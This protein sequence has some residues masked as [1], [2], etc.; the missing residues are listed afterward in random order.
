MLDKSTLWF[1]LH[2]RE[3]MSESLETAVI[4]DDQDSHT[5]DATTKRRMQNR[6]AQRT[7][8]KSHIVSIPTTPL[9]TLIW[10]TW[11]RCTGQR[12]A[13]QKRVARSSDPDVHH[14]DHCHNCLRGT[15]TEGPEVSSLTP[16]DA[17]RSPTTP[18]RGQNVLG[19]TTSPIPSTALRFGDLPPDHGS[20]LDLDMASI[21]THD[22]HQSLGFLYNVEME[23]NLASNM[24][25]GQSLIP[26]G[27]GTEP[28]AETISPRHTIRKSLD[29]ISEQGDNILIPASGSPTIS[30]E[31]RKRTPLQISSDL[32]NHRIVEILLQGG[33]DIN[34]L[35]ADGR[36]A[37][38]YG[39][40]RGHENVVKILLKRRALLNVLDKEGMSVM[41]VAVANN[42]ENI[43][44]LLL[45]GGVNPDV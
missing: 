20:H 10:N 37:L 28:V 23:Q 9:H 32:G 26:H 36:S 17:E 18:Q 24:N 25:F 3:I 4:Q 11:L 33:A 40:Q 42:Q 5:N 8:R 44:V 16:V 15:S 14:G 7:S 6:L 38:Y 43:V 2:W 35:D 34:A 27:P 30:Q 19:N 21:F 41:Q 45:E 12:K 31:N 1:L 22:N 29:G 13:A 39:A